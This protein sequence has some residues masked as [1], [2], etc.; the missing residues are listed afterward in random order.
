MCA[1]LNTTSDTQNGLARAT[2][3]RDGVRTTCAECGWSAT[4][5]TRPQADAYRARH[6]C[7]THRR[8]ADQARRRAKAAAARPIRDCEHTTLRHQHGI[9]AAYISDRC[10]CEPCTAAN[11]SDEQKRQ[12]AIAYGR[13][14]PYLEAE[15]VRQHVRAL[16]A[17]GIGL[18][19]I[20]ELARLP[21]GTVASLVYGSPRSGR[22]PSGRIRPHTATK[23][24]AITASTEAR[25][26]GALVDATGTRLRLQS[27]VLNGW[28]LAG[29][30]RR[31][32]RSPDHLPSALKATA[33]TVATA[34][35]VHALFDELW[36]TAPP[37]HT[38]AERVTATKARNRATRQGWL[39][40]MA[41]DDIDDRTEPPG[42]DVDG[43]A[44]DIDEIAVE[45]AMGGD[46][47]P[48]TRA[49]RDEAV[50]RLT[51]KGY[52]VRQIAERLG[53]TTRTV[54]RRRAAGRAA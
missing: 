13:W 32:G 25:A 35:A 6:S 27:L 11:R 10:R 23:L 8:R 41:W 17:A 43:C 46:H 40:A 9:R 34:Q 36:D 15:P 54:M 28:S 30:A 53:T 16:M 22:T 42:V 2:R 19:R 26:P 37:T 4:Y 12:R 14:S 20:A 21:Y 51:S 49:E 3:P 33:V 24:L 52:S 18:R 45:R 29:L 39:P 31:L 7:G 1:E 44:L 48:L 38:H 47:V 50:R 5:R